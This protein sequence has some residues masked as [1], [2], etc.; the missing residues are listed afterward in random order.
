MKPFH[1]VCVALTTL[2]LLP[3]CGCHVSSHKN[4]ENQNVDIG[5]PFGSMQVKTNKNVNDA[6]IGI[7]PYPGAVPAKDDGNNDAADIN[8]SFGS[9][10]LGV[11]A[12]SFQ[13]SDPQD[14]VLGFYKQD[15]AR[16]GDVLECAG[17]T[18]VG[19][20]KRTSQGLTCV[21]NKDSYPRKVHIGSGL[22]LRTG[23][24]Q[25]QHIVAI[26]SKDGG[27]RIGLVALELPS[28]LNGGHERSDSE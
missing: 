13:T 19:D 15:L 23:S 5:T 10:H 1:A 21:E 7:T 25:H 9:F 26:E 27:T 11:R 17:S 16:Y 8:M 3:L 14:K 12:A 22:E 2:A 28:H 18:P 6:G 4:G 20:P 24:P